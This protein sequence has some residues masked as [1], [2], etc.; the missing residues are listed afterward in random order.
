MTSQFLYYYIV[1]DA[2][3]TYPLQTFLFSGWSE[4]GSD[5]SA[6]PI[7][8]PY[9]FRD[10]GY[11]PKVEIEE[12]RLAALER[13]L[14]QRSLSGDLESALLAAIKEM[15]L[16]RGNI[17]ID[18]PIIAA[19][20]E[21]KDLPAKLR[22]ADNVLRKIRL[23]KSKNEILLMRHAAQTNAEAALIAAK[24]VREGVTYQELRARFFAETSKLG[25]TPAF[26]S[27][28]RMSSEIGDPP[29][30]DGQGFFI[31]CVRPSPALSWRLWAHRLCRRAGQVHAPSYGCD[32]VGLGRSA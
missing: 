10:L 26:M 13:P 31:D 28:D 21:A 30:R 9:T 4:R 18:H 22:Y 8:K 11:A 3:F 16:G 29:I 23:I 20:F 17:G 12:R 15:G 27:V 19:V 32:V 1:A 2:E 24:S 25:N 14:Q 6:P 7:P 5:P